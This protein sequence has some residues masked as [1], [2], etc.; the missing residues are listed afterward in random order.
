MRIFNNETI[1]A[2]DKAT[3]EN[4]N[5]TASDL[6]ERAS[7]AIANEIISRWRP[8]KPISI[9]AGFGNNG[10]DALAVARILIEQGY[11]PEIFLFNIGGNMLSNECRICRDKLL[12]LGDINFTE[13]VKNFTLPALSPNHVVIDGLFGSGL[14]KPKCGGFTPVIKYINE[15]GATIV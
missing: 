14:N 5:V 9:F 6:V 15:S 10:A 2:I 1:R 11:N 3:I 8:N 12:E 4:E 7:E 13:I